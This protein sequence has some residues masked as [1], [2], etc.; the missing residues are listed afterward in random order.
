MKIEAAAAQQL[1][2]PR[3]CCESR[4]TMI[5][6]RYPSAAAVAT[7]GKTW[8]HGRVYLQLYYSNVE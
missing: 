6:D 5:M 3:Y 2:L 1:L 4:K 7:I 8:Y